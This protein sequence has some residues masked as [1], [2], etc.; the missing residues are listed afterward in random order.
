LLLYR[1][2][3]VAQC[4]SPQHILPE[5]GKQTKIKQLN[6]RV[7]DILLQTRGIM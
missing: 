2:F 7:V 6:C 1:F 3:H 4:N 5:F